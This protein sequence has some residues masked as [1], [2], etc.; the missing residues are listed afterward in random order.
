MI[1][2]VGVGYPKRTSLKTTT[3]VLPGT[4]SDLKNEK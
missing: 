1:I 4:D 3:V 2:K